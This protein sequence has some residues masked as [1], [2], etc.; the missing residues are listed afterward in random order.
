M[1]M[2]S[3]K[4]ASPLVLASIG[5]A[6][7]AGV[8]AGT[9]LDLVRPAARGEYPSRVASAA[10]S[11]APGAGTAQSTPEATTW[12]PQPPSTTWVAEPW[13]ASD[14]EMSRLV[15]AARDST[16]LVTVTVDRLTYL[17]GQ[18][19][20]DYYAQHPDRTPTEHVIVNQSPRLYTFR[21]ASATPIFLGPLVGPASTPQPGDTDDLL[22]GVDRAVDDTKVYV[23]LRHDGTDGG[24]VTYL[25]EHH[26][27]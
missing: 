26:R 13:R 22:D 24:W 17:T 12:G 19:A 8:I 7:L 18:D 16:G 1:F 9:A 23:W 27:G 3:Q 11:P 15:S 21:L 10:I 4:V 20:A 14:L 2:A 5:G 6:V 25:A